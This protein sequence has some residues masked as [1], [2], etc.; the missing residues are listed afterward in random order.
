MAVQATH[1][2]FLTFTTTA[3]PIHTSKLTIVCFIGLFNPHI[4]VSENTISITNY[5]FTVRYHTEKKASTR[6]THTNQ[7]ASKWDVHMSSSHSHSTNT[8]GS[9]NSGD[10]S[11]NN[12]S[13]GSG[14][15]GSSSGTPS[16]TPPP[17]NYFVFILFLSF[18]LA[19]RN[20][21]K[22]SH[23]LLLPLQ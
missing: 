17:F 15:N 7:G 3:H 18:Y 21:Y 11:G 23:P 2:S 13:S 6:Q 20:R 22:P 12:S 9:N 5:A 8:S 4:K 16:P 19:S 1:T 10:R 14:D